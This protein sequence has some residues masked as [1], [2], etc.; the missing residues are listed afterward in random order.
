MNYNKPD[1]VLLGSAICAVQ[2]SSSNKN[3]PVVP[4][5][6]FTAGSTSAYEADE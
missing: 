4:D 1:V 5:S 3:K 6:A 2:S